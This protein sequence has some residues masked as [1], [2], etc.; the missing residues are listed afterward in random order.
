MTHRVKKRKASSKSP[1]RSSSPERD[2]TRKAARTQSSPT[3]TGEVEEQSSDDEEAEQLSEDEQLSEGEEDTSATKRDQ[4]ERLRRTA[5]EVDFGGLSEGDV[6]TWEGGE[7]TGKIVGF[8]K[9]GGWVHIR[10]THVGE[11]E[12][13]TADFELFVD[14]GKDYRTERPGELKV[15]NPTATILRVPAEGVDITHFFTGPATASEYITPHGDGPLGREHDIDITSHGLGSGIYGFANATQEQKL[16]AE[17]N[18]RSTAYTIHMDNPLYLQD[19]DHGGRLTELS[20]G[21]QRLAHAFREWNGEGKS[22]DKLG[23]W[24][25]GENGEAYIALIDK[26]EKVVRKVGREIEAEEA[27][28]LLKASLG[29]FFV[30]YYSAA[31]GGVVAQPINYLLQGQLGYDGVYATDDTNNKFN[32]GCVAYTLPPGTPKTT[33]YER[34]K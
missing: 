15:V 2:R 4:W 7:M 24:L 22:T 17:R 27:S 20:K 8:D 5:P 10:P 21:M 33:N 1:P 11:D 32:R 13:T 34:R 12:I 9:A 14:E 25:T 18:F 26:L 23:E 29:A 19:G 6:I 16:E 31:P 3:A 28:E 30:D